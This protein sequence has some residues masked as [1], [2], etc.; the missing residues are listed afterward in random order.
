M[1]VCSG[2]T[3]FCMR[4]SHWMTFL[5]FYSHSMTKMFHNYCFCFN[6]LLSVQEIQEQT[7]LSVH[8]EANLTTDERQRDSLKLGQQV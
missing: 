7:I 5:V 8:E 6:I 2:V 3:T 4:V 1:C